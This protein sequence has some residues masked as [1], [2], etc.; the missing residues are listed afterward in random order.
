[1]REARTGDLA[2]GD[3]ESGGVTIRATGLAGQVQVIGGERA[4][5]RDTARPAGPIDARLALNSLQVVQTVSVANLAV[6]AAAAASQGATRLVLSTREPPAGW[7]QMVLATHPDG[8]V[9]WHFADELA[10]GRATSRSAPSGLHTFHVAAFADD[11]SSAAPGSA[12]TVPAAT[13]SITAASGDA[14][15]ATGQPTDTGNRLWL[16]VIA[17]PLVDPDHGAVGDGFASRREAVHRPHALRWMTHD[18]DRPATVR[19]V[20]AADW[21]LLLSGRSL[22]FVPGLFLNAADTFRGLS[23]GLLDQLQRRYEGRIL[24]FDHPTIG[25]DPRDNVRWLL[26]QLP[27][28]AA[29]DLDIIA[30]GR[31][32]LVSRVLAE[33]AAELDA[34]VRTVHVG[35]MVIGGDAG[36]P[37]AADFANIDVCLA[38]YSSTINAGGSQD[39]AALDSIMAVAKQV[40]TGAPGGLDGITALRADSAFASWLGRASGQQTIAKPLSLDHDRGALRAGWFANAHVHDVILGLLTTGTV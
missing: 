8:R 7:G 5:R 19:T 24:A 12:A 9:A 29:L 4:M 25:V 40:A 2:Q 20:D 11:P 23:R 27:E 10:A 38:L 35:A 39:P 33:R 21:T 15:P 37:A 34:G 28:G 3:V 32:V 14:E 18:D 16:R 26:A 1:L 30:Y 31:G 17:F 13:T 6:R 36:E 22:L